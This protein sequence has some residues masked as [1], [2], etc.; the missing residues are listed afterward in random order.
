MGDFNINVMADSFYAKKLQR[1][2]KELGMETICKRVD[3]N[4]KG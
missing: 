4:S 3:T 1:V 2:I